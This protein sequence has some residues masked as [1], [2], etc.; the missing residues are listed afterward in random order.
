MTLLLR[1]FA[2]LA[3]FVSI[4]AHAT[5][6]L[7]CAAAIETVAAHAAGQPDA[8]PDEPGKGCAHSHASCHGHNIAAPIDDV[9]AIVPA[10]PTG[11]RPVARHAGLTSAR[12]DPALRPP[13]P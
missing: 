3:L 8:E 6:A 7:G 12:I 13:R 11:V 5:E 10:G 9:F 1:L 2:V 4:G